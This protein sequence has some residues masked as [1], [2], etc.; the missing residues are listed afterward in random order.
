MRRREAD[1][2]RRSGAAVSAPVVGI[3]LGTTNTVVGLVSEG[4]AT[5]IADPE[6]QTLLPSV[7]SFPPNGSVL[8]GRAA[9]E[10]RQLDAKN[11]IYSIKRLIGRSW[12]SPELCQARARFPFEMQEGPGHAAM[13]LARGETYTL[14]EISAFVLRKARQVAEAAVLAPVTQAVITVPAHFNDLQRAATKVAGR[15][16]G[17]EVLRILNE[18]TA[19]ALAYGFGKGNTERIAVYDFGGGTFDV[20]LLDLSGDV[21]EVLGTAGDTFLG[22]DDIDLC[23]VE[24]M[25]ER[26]VAQLRYDPRSHPESLERLRIMAEQLKCQLSGKHQAAVAVEDLVPGKRRFFE[27]SLTREELEALANPIVDR[28][29]TVCRSALRMAKVAPTAFDQV[30]LVGGST[31]MPLVRERVASFF[32]REPLG[33]ISPDEVVA[34]GAAIQASALTGADRRRSRVPKP[35]KPAHLESA[36]PALPPGTV[37]FP[38]PVPPRRQRLDTSPGLPP[39]GLGAVAPVGMG[40]GPQESRSGPPRRQT[41]RPTSLSPQAPYPAEAPNPAGLGRPPAAPPGPLPLPPDLPLVG[42]GIGLGAVPPPAPRRQ[43]PPRQGSAGP[44]PEGASRAGELATPDGEDDAITLPHRSEQPSPDETAPRP[45]GYP[46]FHDGLDAGRPSEPGSL[47]AALDLE[48]PEVPSEEE[49]L[50]PLL[51]L[52]SLPGAVNPPEGITRRATEVLELPPEYGAS[53]P[54]MEPVEN[55]PRPLHPP[56]PP[57][58]VDVTPLTLSVETVGGFCDT[59]VARNTPVPCE[60]TRTFATASDHQTAVRVRVSQGESSR[61]RENTLLGEVELAELRPAA[62]GEVQIA[63]TFI[64]DPDG[65]LN[66]RAAEV[67]TGRMT[68]AT[69]RLVGLTEAAEVAD[70]RR[71]HTALDPL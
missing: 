44:G 18:P 63:V 35:P 34:I 46:S 58:L 25:A 11:T 12:D 13:V 19:A 54:P 6:G 71:K 32:G 21:F 3:D 37:P 24:R 30:L 15:V 39:P 52:G 69:L 4:H 49:E 43:A 64:L 40:G 38:P 45:A 2:P 10:R 59:V 66:V 1:A 5:A 68:S 48:V 20:T 55:V 47:L 17:L 29:F 56:R 42:L 65:I 62:R 67:A 53:S 14:P 41:L 36:P 9:K 60:R 31:R 51:A 22:G 70:L 28:T 57:L 50:D 8:V 27:Y 26:S 33:N 23:I 16:A 61:F 7:V